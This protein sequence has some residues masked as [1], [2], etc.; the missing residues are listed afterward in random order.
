[1]RQVNGSRAAILG[2]LLVSLACGES[3]PYRNAGSETIALDGGLIFTARGAVREQ[4]GSWSEERDI[5]HL[6][7]LQPGV[8]DDEGSSHGFRWGGTPDRMTLEFDLR[9]GPAPFQG[10]LNLVE[11]WEL[12]GGGDVFDLRMGNLFVVRPEGEGGLSARQL[13]FVMQTSKDG[14]E[15]LARFQELSPDDPDVPGLRV[16]Q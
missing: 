12:Q 11:G 13:R 1:M 9:G 10:S 14:E 7:I 4:S 15:R 6:L 8:P 16:R 5:F 3:S 2:A